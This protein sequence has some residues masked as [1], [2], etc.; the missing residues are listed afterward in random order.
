[1]PKIWERL[2]IF[3]AVVDDTI[4]MCVMKYHFKIL[5]HERFVCQFSVNF[6]F[7]LSKGVFD[8]SKHKYKGII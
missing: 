3:D 5:W 6:A 2:S 1:M 4:Q 8:C 7:T